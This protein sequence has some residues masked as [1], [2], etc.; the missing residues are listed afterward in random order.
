M[1]APTA[2]ITLEQ[3]LEH[4]PLMQQAAKELAELM[5]DLTE[6]SFDTD[7]KR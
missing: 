2:R 3:A 6:S 4:V 5:D 7:L 1:H